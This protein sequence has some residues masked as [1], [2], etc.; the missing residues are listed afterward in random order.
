MT[1]K[2]YASTLIEALP[3]IKKFSGKTIVIKYGGSAQTDT[4]LNKLFAED[5]V[6]L[7]YIGINVVIVH[8][9]GPQIAET[10]KKIG[11]KS[12]FIEG[13]RVTDEETLDIVEMVL[14]GSTNK[15]I[16]RLINQ[17]GGKAVGLSGSD[18]GLTKAMKITL[19]KESDGK[20]EEIDIGRVGKVNKINPQIIHYLTKGDYIPVIAPLGV[21]DDGN[22]FNIN[23]D[24]AAG[25]IAGS[26]EAEKFILLTDVQGILDKSGIL[27]GSIN[28]EEVQKL[29][30]EDVIAG[31]MI[32]KTRAC[33][34]AL[35]GGV[36]KTHIIDGR[37]PHALL[38][39]VFTDQGVGTEIIN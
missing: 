8:G 16:V 2:E 28:K 36:K 35:S 21:D 9:G 20:K 24:E 34:E 3:Y 33:L 17:Q 27:I 15:S 29:Q 25:A 30:E 37:T 38:L 14:S 11:K 23:A 4:E 7:K 5:I 6:L 31:G 22:V 1:K 12:E 19:I 26:L 32:P 39:E 13:L 18:A 10:L